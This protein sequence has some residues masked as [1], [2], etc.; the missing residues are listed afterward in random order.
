VATGTSAP[1][2]TA[3][4]SPVD[5]LC[6]AVRE[7]NLARFADIVSAGVDPD[8]RASDGMTAL[9]VAVQRN[10]H[11]VVA[12]LLGRPTGKRVTEESE[13]DCG[14]RGQFETPEAVAR[15][16]VDV[17]ARFKDV[18]SGD[19]RHVAHLALTNRDADGTEMVRFL[20]SKNAKLTEDEYD[21]Y[22]GDAGV[23]GAMKY[24]LEVAR[25]R[26]NPTAR[27]QDARDRYDC[28]DVSM[29]DFAL[30]GQSSA[31]TAI[32]GA[33]VA[34]K[35][36]VQSVDKR[37][38]LSILLPGPPGHGKTVLG[39]EIGVA[40]GMKPGSLPLLTATVLSHCYRSFSLL[41]LFLTATALSH[42]RSFSLLPLFR[43]ATALS[44]C[45]RSFS[46]LRLF[47]TAAALSHRCRSPLALLLQKRT[48]TR[49]TSRTFRA[50][51]IC[52]VQLVDMS[53][54]LTAP[55]S[56]RSWSSTMVALLWFCWTNWTRRSLICSRR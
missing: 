3:S 9:A 13:R 2:L 4:F 39:K 17:N 41:L 32:I 29:L 1:A 31:K 45:Y 44:H 36:L 20:L 51:T 15:P 8:A 47:L 25:Y 52:L 35:L 7:G 53:V 18:T 37:A 42:R 38:P 50:P 12:F 54:V 16:R 49:P 26:S 27:E 10:N 5:A 28:A 22:L 56:R 33:I 40:L 46:L 21:A 30:I 43:T 19:L 11:K 34:Y 6:A 14:R 55:S 23:T 48:S 24:W